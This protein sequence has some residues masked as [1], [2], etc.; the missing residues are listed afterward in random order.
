MI[1][2]HCNRLSCVQMIEALLLQEQGDAS[3]IE[4]LKG[5]VEVLRRQ[6]EEL[7]QYGVKLDNW[8]DTLQE[9]LAAMTE[10]WKN[11]YRL[12]T[13]AQ[14]DCSEWRT[15]CEQKTEIMQTHSDE[16]Q[17]LQ[18]QVLSLQVDAKQADEF[19]HKALDERDH[20]LREL[21]A[22]QAEIER[23]KNP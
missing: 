8:N 7:T 5:S 18:R 12:R 14:A 6:V 17:E 19:T 22:A 3:E 4:H 21:E 11:E 23:L 10:L 20:Y 13:E 9:Q 15:A 2:E 1:L 16:R